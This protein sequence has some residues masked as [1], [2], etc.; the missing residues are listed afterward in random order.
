[1][2]YESSLFGSEDTLGIGS[3]D[4]PYIPASES[5]TVLD[6]Q[7]PESMDYETHIAVRKMK[8]KIGNNIIDYV[9]AKLD[10]TSTGLCKSL[11]AEQIDAV[12]MAIYNIEEK[13]QGIIIGDQTG[14]G[15]GRIA[16]AMLRYGHIQGLKPIFFSEKPNLF[17]DIYR[18]LI[19]IGADDGIAMEYSAEAPTLVKINFAPWENLSE[20]EK[21]EYENDSSKYEEF[22]SNP[23]N[24]FEEVYRRIKNKEFNYDQGQRLRPLIINGRQSKTDIIDKNGNLLYRGEEKNILD[25]IFKTQIIPEEYSIVLATYSQFNNEK[26]KLKREFLTEIAKNNV[27]IMDEAHNASGNSSTGKYLQDIL[28]SCKGVTFLSATFAKRPD[29]MPIYAQKT[30]MSEANMSSDELIYAITKG[31][32]ALQEILS[33][34]LVAEGQMLRRERSFEGIEVNYISL[35]DKK[36]EHRAISDNITKLIRDIINFQRDEIKPIVKVL[37]GEAARAGESVDIKQGTNMAGVD[38]TPYFSKV[39]NVIN[40]MLFSIKAESVAELAIQR[41]KEGRKPVIAFSNTMGSFV[42]TLTN[43]KGQPLSVGD[44]INAD[45]STVLQRG[46]ESVMGI[47]E[48]DAYGNSRKNTINISELSESGKNQYFEI[49]ENCREISTGISISPIDVIVDKIEAAGYKVAEVT[50]RRL[51]VKFNHKKNTNTSF[52]EED[53]RPY[54]EDGLTPFMVSDFSKYPLLKMFMPRNQKAAIIGNPELWDILDRMEKTLEVMKK[55]SGDKLFEMY[56]KHSKTVVTNSHLL[57]VYFHFFH[58][59]SDWWVADWIGDRIFCFTLLNNDWQMAEF[60]YSSISELSSY[61]VELDFY[62]TPKTLAEAIKKRDKDYDKSS[63]SAIEDAKKF[64]RNILVTKYNYQYGGFSGFG[65]IGDVPMTGMVMNRKK[66]NTNDA[67]RMFNNNEVDVLLINQSGSTGASAHAIVTDKVSRDKVRQRVM[68]ILQAELNINTEVQKRG[69]INRTGQIMKPIYDYVNSAIPAEKR[70]MMML[71]KKLKSLDA[72][73]TSNQK[74]SEKVL[75]SDDF[76]NKYGDDIVYQYLIENP[77]VNAILGDILKIEGSKDGV[78]EK[79]TKNGIAH[80]A[81]GRVAILPSNEQETFY[82]DIIERYNRLVENLKNK[83]AYDLEVET[84][85]F[86]AET[87][88]SKITIAGKGFGNSKFS[89]DTFVEKCRVVNLKKPYSKIELENIIKQS[90]GENDPSELQKLLIKEFKEYMQNRFNNEKNKINEKYNEYIE[91]IIREKQYLKLENHDDKNNYISKRKVEIEEERTLKNE[92]LINDSNSTYR[93]LHTIFSTFQPGS[94][95]YIPSYGEKVPCAFLGYNVNKS[96]KNPYAPSSISLKFAIADSTKY[97]ELVCSGDEGNV[98]YGIIGA[99]NKMSSYQRSDIIRYW[100]RHVMS[101]SS[102]KKIVYIITGNIL[103]AYS[104]YTGRLISYTTIDGGIKKGILMPDKWD[105]DMQKNDASTITIPI[106]KCLNIIKSMGQGEII[107]SSI[108]LTISKSNH[109]EIIVPKSKRYQEIYKDV[110]LIRLSN[111]VYDGFNMVSNKMIAYYTLDNVDAVVDVLQQKFNINCELD[112]NKYNINT[113][114]TE[115]NN[116]SLKDEDT[117]KAENQYKVDKENFECRKEPA[118]CEKPQPQMVIPFEETSESKYSPENKPSNI[119]LKLAKAKTLALARIRI[120]KERNGL[121]GYK[122][123]PSK[124]KRKEFAKKMQD[125]QF[126]QEYKQRKINRVV[127]RRK[128]SRFDYPTAGGYYIATRGQADFC[129][130]HSDLFNSLSEQ[131]AKNMVILSWSNN[132]KI[133]HDYIHIVNEKIMQEA[134]NNGEIYESK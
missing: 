38:N 15:K 35:E 31:G 86:Q 126:A 84:F 24:Q 2:T 110:D 19:D 14:I 28:A 109:W 20:D 112:P 120:E 63:E 34:Q 72:N 98:L 129:M 125:E 33:S 130:E 49:S 44:I 128:D 133:H 70:L 97:L 50:G 88:E 114:V 103:Q 32:V 5:C 67:F 61:N 99:S 116:S 115:N 75:E 121:T 123:K 26:R 87:I 73:T 101:S 134:L 64:Y 1:M 100:D 25:E 80:K 43:I 69:R 95:Y 131:E 46:L 53:N 6:T 71:K 78:P 74:Q 18:D 132:E 52:D 96:K 21:A 29:N 10:M 106:S 117:V 36:E 7:V 68:I 37:D 54:N 62:F 4:S 82:N 107:N 48:T 79:D 23:D 42:E 108:G 91:N 16:A 118:A 90:I 92:K 102:Q 89:G 11:A 105:P 59:G 55:L 81:S 3:L 56:K 40:Q 77:D 124:S 9:C 12:A 45:F 119:K 51:E 83:G 65:S 17:S 85:D 30:A 13:G 8:S 57:P 41:L 22:V 93:Y 66:I 113:S 122:W 39:F 58:G 104:K 27:I 47:S 111:D 76:L 94:G 60:G 127:N